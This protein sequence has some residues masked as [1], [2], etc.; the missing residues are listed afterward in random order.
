M[1]NGKW[2]R[3]LDAFTDNFFN[4]LIHIIYAP[5]LTYIC[6]STEN[7]YVPPALR[8]S[9]GDTQNGDSRNDNLGYG[10]G[11]GGGGYGNQR[12]QGN[13]DNGGGNGFSGGAGFGGRGG[14]YRS[15]DQGNYGSNSRWQDNNSGGYQGGGYQGGGGGGGYHGGRGGGGGQSYNRGGSSFYNGDGGG[16]GGGGGYSDRGGGGGYGAKKNAMGFHGD[17]RPNPKMEQELFHTN[18]VQTAGINFDKVRFYMNFLSYSA[19]F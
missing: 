8:H 3:A 14:D 2:R 6:L 4:R 17:D 16:G 11:S 9:A 5:I 7:R 15:R 10:G 13:Y 18:E 1:Q 12:Q 19:D